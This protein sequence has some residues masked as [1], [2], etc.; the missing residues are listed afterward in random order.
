MGSVV[1]GCLFIEP[2]MTQAEPLNDEFLDEFKRATEAT[3]ETQSIDPALY[4]FQFQP[5]TRWNPG[6]SDKVIAEYEEALGVHFPRDFKI[7]LR[8]MNGTNLPTLNVY[9]NSGEP[10]R[11]S[12]GV[13]SYPKDIEIVKQRV[14]DVRNQRDEIMADLA[15]Q[16]YHL[17]RDAG[18]V[19]IFAH[20][21]VVCV[22]DRESSVVLSIMVGGVDAIV[23]GNSLREYL[24]REFLNS[25]K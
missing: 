9:G 13:Y 4:G 11:Q 20:R 8:K 16:G 17:E 19:P 15:E 21:Y 2:A 24:E 25:S 7:F 14:E 23:Y 12:V 5:G 10:P 18:L 1:E 3:W 22:P 6:L